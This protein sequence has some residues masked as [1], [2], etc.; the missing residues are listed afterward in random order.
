MQISVQE[1]YGDWEI[2]EAQ[3]DALLARSLD[4]RPA[5]MLYDKM[6]ELGLA[7]H[8][9]VLD[10]GCRDT[11]HAC[12]LA[13][14]YGCRVFGVDPVAR[15]LK[16]AEKMIAEKQLGAQ[17]RAVAGQIEAIPAENGAFDYIWCRDVLTHIP[18]LATGLRECARVLKPGGRMLNYQT[19]ATA[20]LEPN[21]A[22]QLY[23]PLAVVPANMA[24]AYFE[25]C[26]QGTGLV[27]TAR[28]NI[29]SEW[30]E[31]WEENGV[32]TTSK[33][34]LQIARMHRD[35][36]RLLH[37]IGPLVYGVEL[38]NCQWGVYQM[39]GKLCPQLYILQKAN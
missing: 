37:E 3:L 23:P 26:V 27:I 18:D 14:R 2:D 28:D 5:T 6:G 10:I 30:R 36:E 25:Q 13:E 4:P 19:F 12:V 21:E 20:L 24:S 16:L 33:Q 9:V 17:V 15:H 7:S 29:S 22:N 31:W 8:H 35:R 38:A 11:R 39:L 34:L 1:M 32:N